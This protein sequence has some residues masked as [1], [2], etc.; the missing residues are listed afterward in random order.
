MKLYKIHLIRH[1]QTKANENGAYIGSTDLPISSTGKQSLLNLKEKFVYP[2]AQVVYASPSVRCIQ[3]ANIIYPEQKP[4]I[5]AN[6]REYNFGDWEGK[7]ADDLK[8][9]EEFVNWLKNSK[10]N[11]PPN[12]ETGREFYER[13]IN[14]FASL[15]TG[16]LRANIT[17]S[18]IVTHAG[19]ISTVLSVFG[20][21]KASSIDWQVNPG[22]GFSIR[23][24][25]QMWSR[26]NIFEIYDKIPY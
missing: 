23:F 14:S 16:L 5:A 2:T 12:G 1:A 22:C 15:L 11:S 21:P 6:L 7:T 19:I 9:S 20:L 10:E 25:N 4:L 13:T 18:A 8:D 3:S 26:D 17:N 24:T